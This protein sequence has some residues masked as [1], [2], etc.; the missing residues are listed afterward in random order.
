MI[1]QKTQQKNNKD[2]YASVE[3]LIYDNVRDIDY[4]HFLKFCNWSLSEIL[5]WLD[6]NYTTN[7][8]EIVNK[9]HIKFFKSE[10]EFKQNFHNSD[11]YCMRTISEDQKK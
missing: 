6:N 8:N 4:D 3:I 2:L 1:E 9:I 5:E 11:L 10:Y 7:H